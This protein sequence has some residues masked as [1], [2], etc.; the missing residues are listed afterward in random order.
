MHCPH[1]QKWEITETDVFC[2]WCRTKLVDFDLS[3]NQDHLCVNDIVDGLTL[4]LTHTGSVG[5]IRVE[6]IESTQ[7]WLVPHMEQVADQSVQVGKDMIVPLEVNLHDL[8]DDYHETRLA[9]ISNVGTREATLEVAP[10]PK[11][12]INTGGE[13]TVLLDNLQEELMSG[14]LAVTRGLLTVESLTTDVPWAEVEITQPENLPC[15]L[16]QRGDN[17]L[18]FIFRMD[19][20]SL[21]AEALHGGQSLPAEFKGTLLIKLAEFEEPRK[22]TFRVK[23]FLPPLLYIP[24]AEGRIRLEVFSGKRGEI[25]LTLQNGERDEPGHANLQIQAI[26]IDAPWL[27]L[28]GAISYPLNIASGQYHGL[29]LTAT[30]T[31]LGEGVYPARITFVTNTPGELREKHVPVDIEVRDMPI[32]DGTIAIDF[33]TTNSCCAFLDENNPLTLI[34]IGEPDDGGRTTVASAILYQDLFDGSD[35]HYIIGNEAY[36]LSFDSSNAFSAVRQVKRRLGTDKP[37]EITFQFDP[38]KRASYRPREVAA[39]IIKRIL[40]RAEERVGGR[41]VSCTVSHP[42]RF[43]LRQLEDLKEAVV[44][45]GIE[46]NKIKTV[47]EPIGAAIDFIQQK[48]VRDKYQQYHLMVFDFGGGTTDITL[49]NVQNEHPSD[50]LTI[51][52]PEVLGATGDRWFGG[53]DVTDMVMN[54]VLS[55]CEF[56]LRARNPEAL[57]L[58]VPFNAENFTDPRRKRLAQQNR[59]F[60]RFWAEAAKIAISTYGDKHQ[61]ALESN[62]YIDGNNIRSRLPENFQLAVIVD[63][64]VRPTETFFHDEVVPKQEEINEQLRPRLEKIMVM[65]QRLTQNNNV[66]MPDIILLSGKSSALPVV[67]KVIEASFPTALLEPSTNS[68]E[69]SFDLKECVVRGACQLS[70]PEVRA[71]V[72]IRPPKSGALSATTSRLGLRVTDTG[73]AMFREVIDAG[74][75]ISGEGLRQ[76]VRGIVLKRESRIRIMENTSLEDTIIQNGHPNLN[77]TELKVFRLDA[78]L[79]EWEQQH[80]RQITDQDLFNTEIELIVTPNLLVR[81]VA[82][83]PGID[84]SLEFETEA[85]G[86]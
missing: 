53:E 66:E 11:F 61:E 86:W 9:V 51:V 19:E 64:D 45:C 23:C 55:R 72:D 52:I 40:E 84:E 6:R 71:G 85:G 44:S 63:N 77:I 14:Y 3:F 1:C 43:S 49:L 82:R 59:N 27:K 15:K 57:N 38:V 46:K 4:T 75:P 69:G 13:H 5:T 32:F 25:N 48:E 83:V 67:R 68:A 41:I 62:Y 10:R 16:D 56:L 29:T 35:K 28:S 2:S 58:V 37:Y 73:V 54:L 74:M 7:P 76:P 33:G 39:D 34:P 70:N 22:E 24:E 20:R 12:Q 47:H 18:E 50:E 42:S 80:G 36:A 79:D 78:R 60:L 8:T 81:L 65:M 26:E 30:T 31:D 17:R 21:L